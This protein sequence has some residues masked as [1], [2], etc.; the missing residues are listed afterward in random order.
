MKTS[1]FLVA[2]AAS[3]AFAASAGAVTVSG[4]FSAALAGV[5]SSTFGIGAGSTL[6]N[7][8]GFVTSTTGDVSVIPIGTLLTFAPVVATNGMIVNFTSSFGNFSG[9]LNSLATVSAPNAK[10]NFDAIGNFTPTGAL[11]GFTTGLANLTVG[12]T[13]TGALRPGR[14]QPSISGSFTFSSVRGG[15]SGSNT[16]EPDVWAMFIIGF[17]MIG[18]AS[19]RRKSAVAA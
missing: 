19:R 14:P 3:M 4:T 12:F 6:S 5:T 17:G 16:P 7:L 15:G 9:T 10:V 13:Q 1:F 18:V 11:S 8:G 2:A